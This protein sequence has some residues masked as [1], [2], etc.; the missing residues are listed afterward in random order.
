MS[1]KLSESESESILFITIHIYLGSRGSAR[2]LIL[3]PGDNNIM[4][5]Y[6]VYRGVCVIIY[7]Y[8]Y[9]HGCK[10]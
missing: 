4:A 8:K 10:A 2:G 3:S 5:T 9:S 7:M 6:V 1:N